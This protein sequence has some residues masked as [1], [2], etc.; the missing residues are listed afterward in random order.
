M[1]KCDGCGASIV[2]GGVTFNDLRF[3]KQACLKKN[4]DSVII[5]SL[6]REIPPEVL[7]EQ[8][9]LVFEGDCPRCGGSG[10]VDCHKSHWALS[11]FLGSTYGSQTH[12]CCPSCARVSRLKSLGYTVCFGLWCFPWGL[13]FTPLQIGRN[14][15]D[16]VSSSRT[17]ASADLEEF[18]RLQLAA[19]QFIQVSMQ[20]EQE[21]QQRKALNKGSLNFEDSG[22]R[23]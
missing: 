16:M 6:A 20:Q 13:L 3:C 12:V 2:F 4:R 5:K 22:E 23:T 18:V 15:F 8:V 17:E 19:Q 14:I 9:Q 11:Y 21:E 1:A 10:P 7:A